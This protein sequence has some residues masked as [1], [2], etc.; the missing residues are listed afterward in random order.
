M[1]LR[2]ELDEFIHKLNEKAPIY[3]EK[4][5]FCIPKPNIFP[6]QIN[7]IEVYPI[8]RRRA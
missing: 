2:P 5:E 4:L 6:L 8:T 1:A 3:P 7:L